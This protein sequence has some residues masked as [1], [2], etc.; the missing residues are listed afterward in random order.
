M[1]DN[2]YKTSGSFAVMKA[3][4]EKLFNSDKFNKWMGKMEKNMMDPKYIKKN[5]PNF[6][7]QSRDV[8][9]IHIKQT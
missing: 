3:Q 7:K 1:T 6:A 8:L 2:F 5:N 9:S 4:D